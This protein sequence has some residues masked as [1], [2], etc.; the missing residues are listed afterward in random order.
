M[1]DYS[2]S[3]DFLNLRVNYERFHRVADPD[4]EF[5]LDRMRKLAELAGNPQDW[6]SIVHVAGTKGKGSTS[7]MIESILRAAGY[8][9]GLF[10]SPHLQRVEERIALE[11]KP[12]GPGE[13]AA[14]LDR[15]RPA[16]EILDREA[17]AATPPEIGPTYFEILTAMAL[18]GFADRG[19]EAAVLEVGLGGRLDST[20]ICR[21]CVAVITSI[22]Q[23]HT[24]QLGE[25][26]EAIAREKGGIIKPG[27]PTIS[28]VTT[29]GPRRVL[30]EIARQNA[31]PLYELGLDF[32]FQYP[33]LPLGEGPGVRDAGHLDVFSVNQQPAWRYS[34]LVLPLFGRHQAAN[35]AVA[36]AVVWELVKQGWTISEAAIREGLAG[37]AVA[38]R[39]EVVAHRP[40]VILDTAHNEASIEALIETLRENFPAGRR[41]L[42]FAVSR[43]KNVVEMLSRLLPF[44]DDVVFTQYTANPRAVPADE[45]AAQAVALTGRY[46]PHFA[47]P[48]AAWQSLRRDHRPDDLLCVTG[49]FYLAGEM[50]KILKL[51]PIGHS[52]RSEE[53]HGGVDPSL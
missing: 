49:S 1:P 19:V 31:A 38:A 28:G 34:N 6:L 44:F 22:S 39:I 3:C 42:L 25:S 9:T 29:E 16:V 8:R 41:R 10:T 14:F 13:F 48:L 7:A 45:L 21:P 35:A 11:G 12:C 18:A 30:R 27:I 33:P 15:V 4:R 36:A 32:D 51:N 46:Y 43:D 2:A 20:N 47:T 23:D 52:E 37:V 40:T 5:K 24:Q 50:R 26:L 17:A 53:S